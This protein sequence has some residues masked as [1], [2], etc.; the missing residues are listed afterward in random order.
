[1]VEW[2]SECVVRVCDVCVWSVCMCVCMCV[3]MRAHVRVRVT[4]F[5]QVISYYCQQVISFTWGWFS[6]GHK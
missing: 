6:A 2:L 1:M 4:S 5:V 3:Y